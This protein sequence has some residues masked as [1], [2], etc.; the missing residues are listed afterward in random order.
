MQKL[1]NPLNYPLA[2]LA[3]GIVLIAG[4]RVLNVPVFVAVPAAVATAV[5]GGIAVKRWR[6]PLVQL[7]D[8]ELAR[9]L[10]DIRQS[11]KD[12]AVKAQQLL[13]ESRQLLKDNNSFQMDLLVSVE[14]ACQRAS[15]LPQKIDAM[16][17][18]LRGKNSLLSVEELEAQLE[19]V[20][21]RL[22]QSSGIANVH[23]GQLASSLRNN[24]ALVREGNDARQAQT[25]ALS[26]AIQETAGVLQQLQNHLGT[27]DLTDSNRVNELRSLSDELKGFQ[28]N[29]DIL[30][31]G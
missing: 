2:M 1:A 13:T 18:R 12:L 7:D 9:E 4:T 10:S 5:G 8:S 25:I 22:A 16:G 31:A 27:A 24:I 29:V 14:F 26:T 28:E 6:P 21:E 11:A 3:G 23:L 19:S 30:V 17:Q 20:N 15:E